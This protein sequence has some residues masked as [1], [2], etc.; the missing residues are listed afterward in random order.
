MLN[1]QLKAAVQQNQRQQ[2][3]IQTKR[4]YDGEHGRPLS[5]R[6]VFQLNQQNQSCLLSHARIH[7]RMRLILPAP[8]VFQWERMIRTIPQTYSQHCCPGSCLFVR[9]HRRLSGKVSVWHAVASKNFPGVRKFCAASHTSDQ[10]YGISYT[11]DSC[12]EAYV[13][14]VKL[15]LIPGMCWYHLGRDASSAACHPTVVL[16]GSLSH[17]A[18][19]HV[20]GENKCKVLSAL[21]THTQTRQ[22]CRNCRC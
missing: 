2:Y 20:R 13:G 7:T 21:T 11:E 4:A 10:Q 14:P 12:P 3:Y 5:C 9:V 17:H 18:N 19:Q 22:T 6:S 1:H 15:D 8:H 16:H